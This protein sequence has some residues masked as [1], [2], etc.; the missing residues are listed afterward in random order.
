MVLIASCGKEATKEQVEPVDRVVVQP[1]APTMYREAIPSELLQEQ[2]VSAPLPDSLCAPRLCTGQLVT[3]L[4][5]ALAANGRLNCLIRALREWESTR[6]SATP[7]AQ[8]EGAELAKACAAVDT[9]RP[10]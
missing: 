5:D 2:I 4:G 7:L 1:G 9:E 6:A 10:R 8:I 3:W